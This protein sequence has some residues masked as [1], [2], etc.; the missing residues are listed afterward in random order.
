MKWN[1]KELVLEGRRNG[2]KEMEGSHG[3]GLN[4]RMDGRSP[5]PRMEWMD[6]QEYLIRSGRMK[7][8]AAI[9]SDADLTALPATNNI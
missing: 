9:N 2:M 8:K 3:P 5:S 7:G 1:E 4:G 6:K